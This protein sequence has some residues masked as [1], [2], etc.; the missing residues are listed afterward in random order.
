MPCRTVLLSLLVLTTVPAAADVLTGSAAFGDWRA[1]R[2]GVARLIRPQD[3][4]PPMATP[5]VA[6]STRVVPRPDGGR[7]RVPAEFDVSLFA[8]GLVSP[9]TLRAAPNGDM[10]VVES[11]AGRVSVLP[12]GAGP[13][14]AEVFASGLNRPYG[15]AFYPP[16]PEPRY[17][18]VA[19]TDRVVR[20]PYSAGDRRSAGPAETVLAGL[21]TGGGHWTRD[22][23][24]SADGQRM[25][26]AVGSRSNVG[27]DMGASSPDDIAA[28]ERTAGTGAAWGREA[29]RAAVL[30]ADPDGRNLRHFANGIRNCSGLAIQPADGSLW[31]ATNERD[32]LGDNLPPDYATRVG[33]GQFFG[34]PWFY[35]GDNPDPRHAGRR[36][37]LRGR[38]AVPDVLIQPHSAPLGITF[39]DG[40]T[41][42]PEYR[43]DAFVALHGSWN[44]Q[45]PT[46]YKVVRL[47]FEDGRPTGV[48]EDFM[49][50]FVLS[51][52]AVWA[53]PVGVAVGGD[54]ALYVSED[55]NGSIWRVAPRP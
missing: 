10:F 49:T 35:I 19:S 55:G 30:V 2:P 24:F 39:Y 36:D 5:S 41:F 28:L 14:K 46:G 1:D 18:Y 51:R 54:G 26:V 43:G 27:Q 52:E 3:L 33:E 6:E 44:R 12:A 25:Y 53:R 32:G 8:E 47:R 37:D 15:M 17:L 23:A 9:R 29:D 11:R 22:I 31:C 7:P 40:E 21:P 4:P 34:W 45:G 20:F 38:V 50:G 48:Y 16:G 13:V 42:P